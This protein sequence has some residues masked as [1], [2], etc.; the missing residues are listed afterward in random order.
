MVA[1]PNDQQMNLVMGSM[2]VVEA[3]IEQDMLPDFDSFM[4]ATPDLPMS[5]LTHMV[6]EIGLMTFRTFVTNFGLLHQR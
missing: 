1:E 6:P 5:Q 2:V 4:G 3:E